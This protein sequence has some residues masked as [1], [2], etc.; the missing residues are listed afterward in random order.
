MGF[1]RPVSSGFV[2]DVGKRYII[3]A[4]HVLHSA[5]RITVRPT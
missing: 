3:T 1:R 5:F 4:Q 2:V